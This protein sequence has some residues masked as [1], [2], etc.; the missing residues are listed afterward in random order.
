MKDENGDFFMFISGQ[1]IDFMI[2]S[3]NRLK[4]GRNEPRCEVKWPGQQMEMRWIPRQ[5]ILA[6]VRLIFSS[7]A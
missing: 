1:G 7:A 3:E 4:E 6:S 2:G 5:Y